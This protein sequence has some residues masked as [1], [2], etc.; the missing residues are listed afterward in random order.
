V[1]LLEFGAVFALGAA[2]SL[3]CL[4]MCGPIVLSYS[5]ALRGRRL[6]AHLAYNGGRILTYTALGALAGAAGQALGLL[7]KMAGIASA[8]RIGAGAAM[9]LA[10]ILMVFFS[11]SGSLIRI[12]PAG[13]AKRLTRAIGKF[14]LN[15]NPGS[16]FAMGLLLGFLPCGLIYAALLKALDSGDAAGGAL[17]MLAFGLGTAGALIAAGLLS[18]VASVRLGRWAQYVPAVSVAAFGA[19]LLWRG[20]SGNPICHG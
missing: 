14:L 16:K 2:G 11:S 17:T 4:G 5:V 13:A 6:G 18:S 9:I 15:P 3:H 19:V 8:V 7:G 1:T 10:G 20:L 12:Q